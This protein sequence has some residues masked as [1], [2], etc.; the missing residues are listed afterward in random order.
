[1]DAADWKQVGRLNMA[2]GFTQE[3]MG[4]LADLALVTG[5]S[6]DKLGRD[7]AT[8]AN[9]IAKATGHAQSVIAKD[10]MSMVGDVKNFG[11]ISLT[12]AGA[13]ASSAFNRPGASA[14]NGLANQA[15]INA[16][17]N[18]FGFGR[19]QARRSRSFRS[20]NGRS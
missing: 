6:F 2:F 19:S 16:N 13:I 7:I 9:G 5:Q 10:M 8:V 3:H 1:M 17:R 20:A 18:S 11:N 15:P 14:A 4:P 12:E